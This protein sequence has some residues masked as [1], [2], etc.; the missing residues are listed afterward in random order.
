MIEEPHSVDTEVKKEQFVAA[1]KASPSIM[2]ATHFSQ[3][4]RL[5]RVTAWV[6]RF[7]HNCRSR[8]FGKDKAFGPLVVKEIGESLLFWIRCIQS[9]AFPDE[10]AALTKG[11]IQP[12]RSSLATPTIP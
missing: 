6:K 1:T 11:E 12:K 9:E 4:S 2:D 8:K 3:L 7:T 5:L 10:I